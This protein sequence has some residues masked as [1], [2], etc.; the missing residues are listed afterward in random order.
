MNAHSA[1]YP[2]WAAAI[3]I[4]REALR[5]GYLIRDGRHY[6]FGR[7]KFHAA[8]VNK[9]IDDGEAVRVGECVVAWRAA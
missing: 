1:K 8:T 2:R 9:L 5:R 4:C 6:L 7:R 3:P